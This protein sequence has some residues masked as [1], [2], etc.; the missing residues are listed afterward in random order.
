[1]TTGQRFGQECFSRMFSWGS[2]RSTREATC[3]PL[4]GSGGSL[5]FPWE[6]H[7]NIC[8][9]L[10][11]FRGQRRRARSTPRRP[12]GLSRRIQGCRSSLIGASLSTNRLFDL[13]GEPLFP[14]ERQQ[15]Q[16]PP[17]SRAPHLSSRLLRCFSG[18]IYPHSRRERILGWGRRDNK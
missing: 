2:R 17:G 16:G 14:L 4:E 10:A 13:T 15:Q 8:L 18:R 11:C 6:T 3:F 9:F 12:N 5:R 7:F 1:M